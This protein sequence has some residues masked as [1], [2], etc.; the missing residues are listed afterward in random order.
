MMLVRV[1]AARVRRVGVVALCLLAIILPPTGAYAYGYIVVYAGDPPIDLPHYHYRAT[2]HA[3]F[4][5]WNRIYRELEPA[6]Y[7][8]A[9]LFYQGTNV[10][11]WMENPFVDQRDSVGQERAGCQNVANPEALLW[12]VTCQTTHP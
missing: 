12:T 11:D 6:Q 4:R 10:V 1:F 2:T 8:K 3:K 9:S 5:E 7:D